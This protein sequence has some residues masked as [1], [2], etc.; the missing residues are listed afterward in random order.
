VEVSGQIHA[1]AGFPPGKEP[2]YPL[3]RRLGGHQSW[4][5][6]GGEEKKDDFPALTGIST[7]V[8]Q[9]SL[10]GNYVVS[11]SKVR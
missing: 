11:I 1:P 4:S 2:Q 3:D 9:P 8:V 10:T 6:R 5:G 7:V